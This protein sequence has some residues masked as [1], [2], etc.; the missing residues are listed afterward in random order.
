MR[1][2][3][4][5]RRGGQR[6]SGF[7]IPKLFLRRW[8]FRVRA[9]EGDSEV[10]LH[11]GATEG[12]RPEE[13]ELRLASHRRSLPSLSPLPQRNP[14]EED[15]VGGRQSAFALTGEFSVGVQRRQERSGLDLVGGS[16]SIPFFPL[17]SHFS[18]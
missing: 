8:L 17:S 3:P 7:E 16:S 18:F 6:K 10:G 2:L 13:G 9:S 1:V 5:V 15:S 4:S 14:F 11:S 12:G